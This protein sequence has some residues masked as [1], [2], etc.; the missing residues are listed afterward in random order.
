MPQP[1]GKDDLAAL[2]RQ[3]I[4]GIMPNGERGNGRINRGAIVA[5]F[6]GATLLLTAGA[7]VENI[8]RPRTDIGG[9]MCQDEQSGGICYTRVTP[10]S[11]G[12]NERYGRTGR[13]RSARTDHPYRSCRSDLHSLCS[14]VALRWSCRLYRHNN[15]GD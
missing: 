5:A 15:K 8:I 14:T 3:V 2:G 9:M 13:S 7:L 4:T 1:I 11:A 12:K 10:P 6:L